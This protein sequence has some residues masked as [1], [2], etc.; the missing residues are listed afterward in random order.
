MTTPW[1]LK[2]C[3]TLHLLSS[4]FYQCLPPIFHCFP[5]VDYE[6]SLVRSHCFT[7]RSLKMC[8]FYHSSKW[9]MT[10]VFR[11]SLS[12][13]VLYIKTSALFPRH[14]CGSSCIQ[15]LFSI[16]VM[17]AQQTW[18]GFSQTTVPDNNRQSGFS[19]TTVPKLS[20]GWV[21]SIMFSIIYFQSN[22][23]LGQDNLILYFRLG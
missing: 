7:R 13:A 14:S 19:P 4:K 2:F 12:S 23:N 8:Y 6:H 16:P 5:A 21:N 1:A 3:P 22:Q 17:H 11:Y 9:I 18:S 15:D 20:T 10:L